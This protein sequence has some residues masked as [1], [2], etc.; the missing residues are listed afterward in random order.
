MSAVCPS[1]FDGGLHR[2]FGVGPRCR[3]VAQR[4]ERLWVALAFGGGLVAFEALGE[5]VGVV[6]DLFDG[7]W[8]VGHLRNLSRARMACTTTGAGAP[9]TTPIS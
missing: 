5:F 2:A 9:S 8:H 1:A 6:E 7:S 3:C 4:D